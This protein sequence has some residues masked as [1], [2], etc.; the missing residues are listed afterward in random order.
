MEDQSRAQKIGFHKYLFGHFHTDISLDLYDGCA[1]VSGTDAYDHKEGRFGTPGQCSWMVHPKRGE[2]N[3][4]NW[5][6]RHYA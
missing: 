6:L 3:R 2:F 4:T 5:N 1:S